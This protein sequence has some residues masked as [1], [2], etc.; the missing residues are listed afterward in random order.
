MISFQRVFVL[1][2]FVGVFV[3]YVLLLCVFTVLV[4]VLCACVFLCCLGGLCFFVCV[5]V[6]LLVL[7]VPRFVLFFLVW[8]VCSSC[9]FCFVF[10]AGSSCVLLAGCCLMCLFVSVVCHFVV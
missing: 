3:C 5:C 4:V 6:V 7:C 2:W 1:C 10:F 9:C 8:G